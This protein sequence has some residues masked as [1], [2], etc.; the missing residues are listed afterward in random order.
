M[1]WILQYYDHAYKSV[2]LLNQLCRDTRLIWIN[3]KNAIARILKKQTLH[4]SLLQPIDENTLLTLIKSD[5]FL[6]FKLDIEIDLE[7]Q[8]KV[9]MFYKMLDRMPEFEISRIY[10]RHG[11][12]ELI[13]LLAT[14]HAFKTKQDFFKILEFNEGDLSQ[15]S[16]PFEYLNRISNPQNFDM[17]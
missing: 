6:L 11:T 13:N 8:L 9:E 2:R 15:Q 5:K 10:V 1:I 7:N 17:S 4:I 16:E 12:N 14:K 3:N